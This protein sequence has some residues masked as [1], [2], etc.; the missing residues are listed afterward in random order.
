M[1]FMFDPDTYAMSSDTKSKTPG[2][3]DSFRENSLPS[4]QIQS[5]LSKRLSGLSIIQSINKGLGRK[6]A[7][8]PAVSGAASASDNTRSYTEPVSSQSMEYARN[9]LNL[10]EDSF[11][12][13]PSKDMLIQ[14]KYKSA[15]D[16]DTDILKSRL[17]RVLSQ[18]GYNFSLRQSITLLEERINGNSSAISRE[19][20]Q[21]SFQQEDL[22]QPGPA[23]SIS[24]RKLRGKVEED[25][26]RRH[27]L[28]LHAFQPIAKKL[29][30]LKSDL[31]DLNDSYDG[32]KARLAEEI[33]KSSAVRQS[34]Q[35][36]IG[37]RDMLRIKKHLLTSFQDKFML[38]Q[39][40]EHYLM[41]GDIDETYF[42]ILQK[43]ATICSN[44]D[45]L[46]GMDN[47]KLGTFIMTKMGSIK[48]LATDRMSAYLQKNLNATY[49]QDA[50]A[51]DSQ[52]VLNLQR[53]LVYIRNN[54]MEKFNVIV[55]GLIKQRSQALVSDF[56]TQ[57]KDYSTAAST[58]PA[59]AFDSSK[60]PL[61][62]SSYDS[63]RFTSD[64]LAYIHSTIVNELE[65]VES[66]FSFD[67]GEV[68]NRDLLDVIGVVG[69]NV[70]DSLSVPLK[71]ALESTV[72]Q[73]YN[74]ETVVQ[75][76][77]LI[78][79]YCM[80]YGKLVSSEKSGL[81]AVL[82][83]MKQYARDRLFA[84]IQQRLK[85]L[86]VASDAEELDEDFLGLPDWLVDF[87]TDYL[88]MFDSVNA[89]SKSTDFAGME[90]EEFSRLCCLLV[91]E[92]IAILET[93][94]KKSTLSQQGKLIFE[95]NA[96]DFIH[97]KVEVIPLLSR[98]KEKYTNDKLNELISKITQYQFTQL[99]KNSGLFDIY[100]LVNM[101]FAL[102]D[103]FFDV[104]VYEP[105]TQNKLF[106]AHTFQ[107]AN[108]KLQEYL[109]TYI[110]SDDL[111][112][113][114]SP[115]ILSAVSVDPSVHFVKF[116]RKLTLIVAEY[117]KDEN[118]QPL[119]VFQ[120]DYRHVATLLGVDDSAELV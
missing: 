33:G 116:Y 11:Q 78:E 6:Q 90:D 43:V 26:L 27:F 118:D 66:L 14:I 19:N 79:L 87:Y 75:L 104:S 39:Y 36:K 60:K 20:G 99:L 108:Q 114:I 48:D 68:K 15:R 80:M 44:C 65:M 113:I 107:V 83:Q 119:P 117:L 120:W 64:V 2:D 29:E 59:T 22:V 97:S 105:I 73:E 17:D 111:S 92:P 49:H 25:I 72:R 21:D 77:E 46:L 69:N 23:G 7:P 3:L 31:D 32:I 8:V 34:L 18:T 86:K 10:L 47:D 51:R 55:H 1:D 30:Y 62:M 16:F 96:V 115:T 74:I 85:A 12:A 106:N 53:S 40:D 4:F 38:S 50:M 71:A 95:I 5:H 13:S 110:T 89:T 102:E 88:Q 70:V 42:G 37:Q 91:D 56:N 109:A 58:R 61:Y 100:N 81:I 82:S 94:A 93:Q 28:M 41:S 67:Q 9:S 24:R 57:L 112:K 84:L 63:K 45:I 76:Y 54:S 98:L 52:N 103:D 101:I 35:Q